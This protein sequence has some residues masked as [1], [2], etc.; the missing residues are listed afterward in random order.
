MRLL[1]TKTYEFHDS[2]D[3][4]VLASPEYAVLSHRWQAPEVTLQT[5]NA[6]D[7]HNTALQTPQLDKIRQA[8]AKARDRT[9]PLSWLWIDSCCIDKTNAVEESRSINS[10][11]EWYRRAVLCIVYMYD[12][13]KSSPFES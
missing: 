7:L 4:T 9:P 1:N 3:P 8:C 2:E 12:V 11:F 10:M 6:D 5:F 13:D